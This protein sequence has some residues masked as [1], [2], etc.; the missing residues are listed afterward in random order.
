M[1]HIRFWTGG[2]AA[3]PATGAG[4]KLT[5][6]EFKEI[7]GRAGGQW[8]AEIGKTIAAQVMKKLKMDGH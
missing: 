1:N 3:N 5:T 4:R 8:G 7:A 6:P 2:L